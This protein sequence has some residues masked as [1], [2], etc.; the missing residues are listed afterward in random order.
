MIVASCAHALT[1]ATTTVRLLAPLASVPH[2]APPSTHHPHG[3]LTGLYTKWLAQPAWS[4]FR[5]AEYGSG[6]LNVLN[7]THAAWSWLRNVDGQGKVFD[8]TTLINTWTA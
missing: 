7:A 8:S 4:A 5:L 1:S 2:A 3:P 6:V